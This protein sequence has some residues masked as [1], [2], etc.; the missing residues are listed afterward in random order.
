MNTLGAIKYNAKPS[1]YGMDRIPQDTFVE[2]A[3]SALRKI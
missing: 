3:M 1:G 2:E